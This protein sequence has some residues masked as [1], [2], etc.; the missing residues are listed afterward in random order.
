M[1]LLFRVQNYLKYLFH[2]KTKYY[3]HSPF[4]YQFYLNVLEGESDSALESLSLLRTRLKEN[5][6]IINASDF[7]TGKEFV[8]TISKIESQISVRHKYGTL[9]YRLV[10]YFQP[11]SI[12]EIGTSIGLSSSYMA[13]GSNN[14][15]K[16]I[17]LEGSEDIAT[18]ARHNHI[19][20]GVN[21]IQIVTGNFNQT[22]SPA[23]KNFETVDF[24]FFDGNHTKQATINYFHQC[25]SYS[26]ENSIFL[27]DDIYWNKEMSEAW[28]E[29][30]QDENVTLTI[31]VY[32]FGICFFRNEKLAKE[33]FVLWY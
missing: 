20:L 21:N 26:N 27:F 15:A 8:K 4:V 12:F 24:V 18:L 31:D 29:I 11:S 6:S 23:L 5:S 1:N 9:L 16:I 25:L 19:S 14:N 2:A 13:L 10:N 32:Q 33:N 3:L 17:T 30:K 22:V 7:G 28:E